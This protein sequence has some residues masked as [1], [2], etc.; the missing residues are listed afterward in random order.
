MTARLITA[1]TVLC[2]ILIFSLTASMEI[3]REN[4]SIIGIL[5][6][7]MVHCENEDMASAEK[8]AAVLEGEW[9]SYRRKMS[10]MLREEKLNELNVT[11]AKIRPYS[12]EANDE[13]EAEIENARRQLQLLYKAEIPDFANIF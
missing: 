8:T 6:E 2:A 13:L 11:I 12:E 5:D 9:E 1:I 4:S 7:I 3:R 10:F